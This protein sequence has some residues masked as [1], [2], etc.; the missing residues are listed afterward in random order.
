MQTSWKPL[1]QGTQA[2]AAFASIEEIASALAAHVR[3]QSRPALMKAELGEGAAGIALFFAYLR[4]GLLAQNSGVQSTGLMPASAARDLSIDC[5]N[6]GIAALASQSTT[7]SLFSGFTGVAWS[8]QHVTSLLSDSSADLCADIDL[9]LE[10]CLGHSPWKGE[11]DLISGL[12]GVGVYCLE[13]RRSQVAA[14]CLH[15]IVEHL[16]QMAKNSGDALRWFTSPDFLPHQQRQIYPQGYYNLGLAHGVPGIIALLAKIYAAGIAREP[17]DRL[18]HGAIKWLLGQR[19]PADANSS[20][21]AFMVP[22]CSPEDCRLAWCYGDA[23]I[24]AALLLAARC[25]GNTAWEDQALAIARKAAA[26]EPQG[27]GVV[28]ACFCHGSAGLLHIFNRFYQAT[29]DEAFSQAA[30]S[31]AEWTLNFHKPATEAVGYPVLTTSSNTK[32]EFQPRFGIIE[33]IAGIGLSLLAATTAVVPDWDRI[34]MVDIPP[35][36]AI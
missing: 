34:F 21:S 8:A 17:S 23:G 11:Y 18:L 6:I 31:W 36:S 30:R 14:R 16:S 4:A 32:M 24:S 25:T 15:L 5:L 12:V 22:D 1:L 20:F 27:C 19:L 33:G 7:A 2:Q 13:R 9:A 10:T 26:R 28:D 35:L 3:N 29:H